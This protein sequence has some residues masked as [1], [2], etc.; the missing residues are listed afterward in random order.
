MFFSS[1]RHLTRCVALATSFA[2][3]AFPDDILIGEIA[4]RKFNDG[5]D[6]S[7][8]DRL[9]ERRESLCRLKSFIRKPSD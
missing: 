8:D 2:Q 4:A 6:P 7:P 9:S 3:A 5:S 1:T